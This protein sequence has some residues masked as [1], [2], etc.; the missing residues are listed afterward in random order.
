M[1]WPRQTMKNTRKKGLA[2]LSEGYVKRKQL[3]WFLLGVLILLPN[4]GRA[5]S[6][7]GIINSSRAAPWSRANVGVPG[8]IPSASWKQCGSTIAAYG[9]SSSPGSVATINNA[10]AA[11][12]NS[13]YLLWERGRFGWTTA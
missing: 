9:S 13:T 4:S 7:S 11:C 2:C 8:G 5:Q 10:I 6:W 12:P 1:E 3:L